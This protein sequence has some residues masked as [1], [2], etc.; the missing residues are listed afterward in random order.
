MESRLTKLA[1]DWTD[2]QRRLLIECAY[3][4]TVITEHD[5]H[6]VAVELARL[7]Q[8]YKKSKVD[9]LGKRE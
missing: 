1:S 5:V 7:I 4:A 2:E 9:D 6:E 8:E 3:H